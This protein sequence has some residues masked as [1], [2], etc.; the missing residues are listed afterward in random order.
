MFEGDSELCLTSTSGVG[1]FCEW[2]CVLKKGRTFLNRVEKKW[3]HG[4][5]RVVGEADRSNY[6][7]KFLVMRL[8]TSVFG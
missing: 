7:G 8:L 3:K 2:K 4:R 1:S 6:Q 5:S